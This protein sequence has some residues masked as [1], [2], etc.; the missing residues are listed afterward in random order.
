[1]QA[2]NSVMTDAD[3]VFKKRII[4]DLIKNIEKPLASNNLADE[5]TI[6]QIEEELTSIFKKKIEEAVSEAL[7]QKL[8]GKISSTKKLLKE[9]LDIEDIRTS[10][11]KFFDMFKVSDLFTDLHELYQNFKIEDKQEFYF[12]FYDIN[13]QKNKYPIFYIPFSIER[14]QDAFFISFDSQMYINKKALAYIV[15]EYNL[16]RGKVG[17]LQTISDRI[18]Y[19][20]EHEKDLNLVLQ[21]TL[22]EITNLFE[23][24]GKIQIVN[25]DVQ[26]KKNLYLSVST[27]IYVAL[28]DKSDEALLNDYED[29]LNAPADSSLMQ[30]FQTLI[31]DFIKENPDSV[32]LVIADEWDEKGCHERLVSKSPIPLNGEQQ[33]ILSAINNDRCK[34]LLVEGPPGTGKSH[35]I[36][37]IVFDTILKDKSVLVIS[38]KKEA[39]DVVE[40]NIVNTLN[41]VRVDEKFQNPLLRLGKTGNTYSQLLTQSSIDGITEHFRIIRSNYPNLSGQIDTAIDNLRRGIEAQVLAY[42]EISLADVNELVSLKKY[43]DKEGYCIDV[44][45]AVKESDSVQELTSTRTTALSLKKKINVIVEKKTSGKNNIS[46]DLKI[47]KELITVASSSRPRTRIRSIMN[48]GISIRFC[49]AGPYPLP[50]LK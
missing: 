29:I 43:F 15:Q 42:K 36:T 4:V 5:N 12:Y 50:P 30:G 49:E 38:D 28:F 20:S 16:E 48:R 37:A 25:P 41:K 39:L 22:T 26:T 1:M 14:K 21:E 34:Y 17:V 24:D 3:S 10:L 40:K 45:E 2:Y 18:I 46:F 13:Y 9:V 32:Q 23:L 8:S 27:N 33:Q 35:T 44:D 19:L 11:T 6:F 31:E 7:K 47:K